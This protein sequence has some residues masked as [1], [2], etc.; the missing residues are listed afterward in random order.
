MAVDISRSVSVQREGPCDVRVPDCVRAGGVH[1][2]DA[3]EHLIADPARCRGDLLTAPV[4]PGVVLGNPR[5]PPVGGMLGKERA[6]FVVA[7]GRFS[8]VGH[9][10]AP[11]RLFSAPAISP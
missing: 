5:C 2:R 1:A 9:D 11:R 4:A 7:T 8:R 6:V 3:A 10:Q